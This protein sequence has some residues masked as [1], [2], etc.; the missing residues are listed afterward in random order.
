MV[1]LKQDL[2]NWPKKKIMILERGNLDY[3]GFYLD[4]E[5]KQDV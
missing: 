1:R 5:C 4:P 3:L 2:L